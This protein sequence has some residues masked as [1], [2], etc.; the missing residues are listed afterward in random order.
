MQ[1]EPRT[2]ARYIKNFKS[3]FPQSRVAFS[4]G[5]EKIYHESKKEVADCK[6]CKTRYT[7]RKRKRKQKKQK[8]KGRSKPITIFWRLV[9]LNLE[10]PSKR[11]VVK[12]C[13]LLPL[14]NHKDHLVHQNHHLRRHPRRPYEL[15]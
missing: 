3:E 9:Y 6:Y 13:K 2:K 4:F 7:R 10:D 12:D 1:L 15:L 14:R 5:F 8:K 11:K